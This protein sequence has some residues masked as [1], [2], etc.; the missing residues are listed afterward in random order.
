MYLCL[1]KS[2]FAT[3]NFLALTRKKHQKYTPVIMVHVTEYSNIILK[4]VLK[5]IA[6]EVT[7]F[8]ISQTLK[9]SIK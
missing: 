7:N 5:N 4:F 1:T 8:K 3:N 2:A 9:K 6:R